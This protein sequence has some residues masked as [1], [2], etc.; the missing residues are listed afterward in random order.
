MDILPF[1]PAEIVADDED[2]ARFLTS[3]GQFNLTMVKHSAFLPN[4]KDHATSVFRHSAAPVDSLWRIGLEH[5]AVGRTLHG[6][7]ICKARH[8]RFA[9][10]EVQA[11]EPPP[12]HADIIGWPL[13]PA[14]PEMEKAQHKE[15]AMLVA[16]YAQLVRR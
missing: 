1:S 15:L 10:L 16:Q 13:Q 2:L 5:A 4:P 12:R 8:V 6:A 11:N 9:K 7:A 3:S 14:D